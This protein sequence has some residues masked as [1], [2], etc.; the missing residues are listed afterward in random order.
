MAGSTTGPLLPSIVGSIPDSDTGPVLAYLQRARQ[1]G[2]KRLDYNELLMC[3]LMSA[4][5]V[6]A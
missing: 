2:I 3:L 1:A 5:G 4:L 6:E